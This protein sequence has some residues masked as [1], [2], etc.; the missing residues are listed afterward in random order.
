M[1]NHNA[2]YENI[3]QYMP[4]GSEWEGD[5]P[6]CLFLQKCAEGLVAAF[7]ESIPLV[8]PCYGEGSSMHT[9]AASLNGSAFS[10][11][12]AECGFFGLHK[13][14]TDHIAAALSNYLST[15]IS[16]TFS[17]GCPPHTH[18]MTFLCTVEE[19]S[20]EF[21]P[22]FLNGQFAGG[23]ISAIASAILDYIQTNAVVTTISHPATHS[24]Q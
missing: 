15:R 23:Y 24:I 13:S 9:H 4:N 8:G 2:L 11:K 16:F 22:N 10:S 6:Q 3:L 21:R 12:V 14:F 18:A 20:S 5:K 7:K 17:E 1:L 19:L